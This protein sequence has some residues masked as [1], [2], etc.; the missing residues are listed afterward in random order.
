MSAFRLAVAVPF[1]ALGTASGLA[2][3]VLQDIDHF[4]YA[5]ADRIAGQGGLY[6]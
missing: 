6:L 1:L 5:A 2:A 4:A 3:R